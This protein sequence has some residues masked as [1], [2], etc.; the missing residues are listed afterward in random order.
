MA[1]TFSKIGEFGRL[2]NQMFQIASAIGIARKNNTQY[3]FPKWGYQQYFK[4]ALPILPTYIPKNIVR[5]KRFEYDEYRL[6]MSGCDDLHGYFQSEKYWAHCKDEVL[7]YFEFKHLGSIGELILN[8]VSIHVR[9]G[10]YL[11]LS[12]YHYNLPMGWYQRAI[13]N[14][15]DR[16]FLVFSD[17]IQWCKEH[18]DDDCFYFSEGHNEITDLYFMSLCQDHIIANSSFSWWATY[19]NKNPNKRVVAPSQWFGIKNSHVETKDLYCKG[20]EIL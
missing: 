11:N 16:K 8:P 3:A 15:P 13:M 20:W 17:D 6:P 14:F 2:G 5:E 7:S 9:R 18:F 1:I 12:D 19:L 4:K 10:D